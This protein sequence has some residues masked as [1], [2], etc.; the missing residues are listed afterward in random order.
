MTMSAF[1]SNPIAYI[2]P[3]IILGAVV[4]YYLY[5]AID[6]AGLSVESAEA[7][8]TDKQMTAGSTTY[9]TNVAGGRAWTQSQQNPDVYAV[10]LRI[11]EERTVGVVPQE[12]FESL[13]PGDRVRVKVRRTRIGHKLEVVEI[14]R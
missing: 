5:G 9:S 10:L 1:R 12:T 13:G 14:S 11:G 2:I 7:V 8:V 4:L 6:R 3:A